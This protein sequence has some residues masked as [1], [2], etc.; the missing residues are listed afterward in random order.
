MDKFVW[1]YIIAVLIFSQIYKNICDG[2]KWW[3]YILLFIWLYVAI[4][5]LI[6]LGYW[7]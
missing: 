2:K 3:F 6:L 7:L 1:S 5:G 4:W